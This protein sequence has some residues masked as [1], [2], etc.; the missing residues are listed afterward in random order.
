[1]CLPPLQWQTYDIDYTA[2]AFDAGGKKTA[3]AKITVKLNGTVIHKD[4][5]LTH[6]TTA[7]P[8]GEGPQPGPLHLQDH[9]NPVR[10][11][12]IWLVE[13]K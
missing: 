7:A 2:A 9:G 13:K 1:M 8:V 3:S 5:D 12:N 10:Y 6:G 11:R 4:V